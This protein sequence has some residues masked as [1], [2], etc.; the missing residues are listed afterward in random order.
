MR[1]GIWLAVLSVCAIV[2]LHVWPRSPLVLSVA[3]CCRRIARR[4]WSIAEG[5]EC[6]YARACEVERSI[7]V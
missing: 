7:D 2:T 4:M 3:R 1:I 6:G 5:I